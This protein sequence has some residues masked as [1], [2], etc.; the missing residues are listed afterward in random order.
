MAQVRWKTIHLSPIYRLA[1]M[2][3]ERWWR[4]VLIDGPWVAAPPRGVTAMTAW[5]GIPPNY[6][7]ARRRIGTFAIRLLPPA[8][9]M[10]DGAGAYPPYDSLR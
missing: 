7:S 4:E 8:G 2:S 5:G 3:G 10:A 1:R 9:K 6:L